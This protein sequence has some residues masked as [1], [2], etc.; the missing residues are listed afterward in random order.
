MLRSQLFPGSFLLENQIIWERVREIFRCEFL[1]FDR[2]DVRVVRE[3]L[4]ELVSKVL[5]DYYEEF[6]RKINWGDVDKNGLKVLYPTMIL[7][8]DLP[9]YYIVELV[10]ASS[11]YKKLTVKRT[12]CVSVEKY[13]HQFSDVAAGPCV[14]LAGGNNRLSDLNIARAQDHDS[15]VTRFP[16]LE[17][18][19]KT[20]FQF[21]EGEGS[22]IRLDDGFDTG[23]LYRCVLIN[24]QNNLYRCKNIFLAFLMKKGL[25]R[26]EVVGLFEAAL[27]SENVYAAHLVESERQAR[28]V[29]GG[30]LQNLYLYEGLHETT[31]GEFIRSHPEIVKKA[32][33]TDNFIYEPY[34]DWKF[35]P[36]GCKDTAINP[37]LLVKR[38]DGYYD[39]YDLKTALL[40][41]R[42]VTKDDRNRRRFIDAVYEGLNQLAN[43]REYFSYAENAEHARVKYGVE[44]SLPRLVLVVGNSENTIS[45][46]VKEAC[47]LFPEVSVIDWDTMCHLFLSDG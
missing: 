36:E 44:V 25:D 22:V 7:I 42:N 10:G 21:T 38:E 32:F 26:K 11:K 46:E 18:A 20:N 43:Y 35:K 16:F 9:G 30:Q 24:S 4:V 3:K 27:T 33:K 5:S 13:F 2:E 39:I 47:R 40:K 14:V 1:N 45:I 34:F 23:F 8:T 31:I 17:F 15:V 37:D 12:S 19:S 6:N 29:I 41:R 28:R